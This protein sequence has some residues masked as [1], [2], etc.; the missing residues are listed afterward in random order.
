[1]RRD[2]RGQVRAAVAVAVF[3]LTA[4]R[5]AV[6]TAACLPMSPKTAMYD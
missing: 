3:V 6:L 4:A 1:M 5:S 2:A